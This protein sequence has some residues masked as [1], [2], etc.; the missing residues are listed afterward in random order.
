MALLLLRYPLS[1]IRNPLKATEPLIPL[2]RRKYVSPFPKNQEPRTVLGPFLD[3][4]CGCRLLL[5]GSRRNA[6]L[7]EDAVPDLKD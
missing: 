2:T 6:L 7:N 3:L 4:L 5:V 1:A